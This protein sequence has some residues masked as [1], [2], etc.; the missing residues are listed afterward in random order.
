MKQH[1]NF[2]NTESN[3]KSSFGEV[4]IVGA[5]TP[6]DGNVVW[7]KDRKTAKKYVLYVSNGKL[8]MEESEE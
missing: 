4:F 3:F 2:E 8:M 5:E 1:V 6:N 7:L